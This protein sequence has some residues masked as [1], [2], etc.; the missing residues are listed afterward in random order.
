M[1]TFGMNIEL[2]PG[3][4]G[5]AATLKA[6][7]NIYLKGMQALCI[8]VALSAHKTGISLSQVSS[9]VSKMAENIAAEDEMD[10]WMRRG[11]L[12]AR[13]KTAEVQDIME[14]MKQW[15][16]DPVMMAATASRLHATMLYN[17]EDHMADGQDAEACPSMIEVMDKIGVE[18]GLGLR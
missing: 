14:M 3:G 9:L 4:A 6:L 2:M 13:R 16:V 18:R 15:E 7:T 17:L 11:G 1:E 10:F 12:H 5:R 8:E